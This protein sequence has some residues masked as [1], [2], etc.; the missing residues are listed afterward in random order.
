MG[1]WNL[2]S[3]CWAAFKILGF[4]VYLYV[5]WDVVWLVWESGHPFA[6]LLAA[7]TVCAFLAAAFG[8]LVDSLET[9][10]SRQ[11]AVKSL[12]ATPHPGP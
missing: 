11:E 2:R 3:G 7:T 5:G 8:M 9:W 12:G 4:P 1:M 10:S 6:G